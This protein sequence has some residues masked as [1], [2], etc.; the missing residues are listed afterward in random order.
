MSVN[1]DDR[2]P[3]VLLLRHQHTHLSFS[4][5]KSISVFTKPSG[6]GTGEEN[7]QQHFANLAGTRSGGHPPSA[8]RKNVFP[9][10]HDRAH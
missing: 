3:A 10:T 5:P 8:P 6:R 4:L 7:K 1:N 2:S 9:I